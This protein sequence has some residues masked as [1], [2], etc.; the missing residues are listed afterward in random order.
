MTPAYH[1]CAYFDGDPRGA[2]S[3]SRLFATLPRRSHAYALHQYLMPW[4]RRGKAQAL[5]RDEQLARELW[6]WCE[7]QVEQI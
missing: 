6:K 4:A 5:A 1:L 7:E 2:F 3:P